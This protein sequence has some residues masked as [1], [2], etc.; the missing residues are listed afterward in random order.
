MP[1]RNHRLREIHRDFFQATRRPGIIRD[2]A[3]RR[4]CR[5]RH[6]RRTAVRN[7]K[8]AGVLRQVAMA[9]VGHK[10]EAIYRRYAI[11]SPSDLTRVARQLDDAA[12]IPAGI[13][14][15]KAANAASGMERFPEEMLARPARIELAAP[16]LG[17]GC[18]I[19]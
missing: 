9:M 16:R 19:P 11:V 6:K 14:P 13:A 7:L 3:C 12:G 4:L 2:P 17:G 10:T 5:A 8:R 15:A 18:S 1:S